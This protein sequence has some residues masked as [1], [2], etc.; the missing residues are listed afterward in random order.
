[1]ERTDISGSQRAGDLIG[2]AQARNNPTTQSH[3]YHSCH[4][5][6]HTPR[7]CHFQK[8][9]KILSQL[10]NKEFNKKN[11]NNQIV[12]LLNQEI[13][14]HWNFLHKSPP[15]LYQLLLLEVN[16]NIF[17]DNFQENSFPFTS[18]SCLSWIGKESVKTPTTKRLTQQK[19]HFK[20][21]FLLPQR[22]V[23]SPIQ[24]VAHQIQ[25]DSYESELNWT[26]LPIRVIFVL[27]GKEIGGV[28]VQ[29]LN[30]LV[31]VKFP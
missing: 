29:F 24:I 20:T 12:F 19:S 6:C 16:P 9:P 30:G 3:P 23:S 22:K 14:I 31:L 26:M 1:M 27:L 15:N 11:N 7:H 28:W 25:E 4:P 17:L 5:E 18:F 2:N 8:S 21:A 10:F 13:H